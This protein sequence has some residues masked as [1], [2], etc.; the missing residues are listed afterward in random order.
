MKIIVLFSTRGN[1]YKQKSNLGRSEKCEFQLIF[2]IS[3][4]NLVYES[5]LIEFLFDIKFVNL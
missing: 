4:G 2:K 1:V 3:G 5:N